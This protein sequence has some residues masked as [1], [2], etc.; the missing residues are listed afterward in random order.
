MFL[1]FF[2]LRFLRLAVRRLMMSRRKSDI[3]II[4]AIVQAKP[5]LDALGGMNNDRREGP[6]HG[7]WPNWGSAMQVGMPAYMCQ[8]LCTK[9]YTELVILLSATM[10]AHQTTPRLWPGK[11]PS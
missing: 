10:M 5:G 6:G 2:F 11:N 3:E 8:L 1:C 4:A 7:Y 9:D